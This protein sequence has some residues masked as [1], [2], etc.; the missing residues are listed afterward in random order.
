MAGEA[1]RC[2]RCGNE[3]PLTEALTAPIRDAL[4][5]EIEVDVRARESQ[6]LKREKELSEKEVELARQQSEVAKS[7]ADKVEAEKKKISIEESKKARESLQLEFEDLQSQL[8]EKDESLHD[9][10]KRELLLLKQERELKEKQEHFDLELTRKLAESRSQIR[11]EAAEAVTEEH[12]LATADLAHE[13]SVLK[14][15]IDLLKKKAEQGSQQA[16]GE[17]LEIE[18]LQLLTEFFPE[19]NINPVSKGISGA[20]VIQEVCGKGGQTYGTI[21]WE[22]K[23]TKAW[24]DSWIEKLK[25]DQRKVKAEIAVILTVALPKACETFVCIDGVWVTNYKCAMGLAFALRQ[26]ILQVAT[27]QLASVD[28]SEK[29]ELLYS[30][31]TG[32]EFKGRVESMV[33]AFMALKKE[34]DQEKRAVQKLWA[35]REKQL[36]KV[37]TNLSG[38]YGDLQGI[39]GASIPQI[40]HLEL[41]AI[42]GKVN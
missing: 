18:L 38:M 11:K 21:V 17:T 31:L 30:Y 26:T 25:T 19:D 9:A 32:S 22:S 39:A 4:K 29:L 34:L 15:Q 2:Q 28:K 6:T 5:A 36:E 1:I 33:E 20:D 8:K 23:R 13:N 7:V 35:Q 40:K 24:R 41:K 16:Q 3:I 37:V 42:P 14:E 27:V 10:K 12:R